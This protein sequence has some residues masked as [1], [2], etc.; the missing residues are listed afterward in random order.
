MRHGGLATRWRLVALLWVAFLVRGAFYSSVLP[1]W[2]GFDEWAHFAVA[3][4]MATRGVW[5]ADRKDPVS[6]EVL[7]S[8]RLAPEP[9]DLRQAGRLPHDEFWRLPEERRLSL[10]ASLR[11]L[12]P[13]WSRPV[14]EGGPRVYEAQQAPLYYWLLSL[15][16][17]MVAGFQL[18]DRVWLLRL[19]TVAI[20]SFTVPLTFL[21]ARRVSV[22][23]TLAAGAA[24]VVVLM[25]GLMM[26]CCRIG[27]EALAATLGALC[28]LLM[29]ECGDANAPRGRVA[30]FGAAFGLALLTKATFLALVPAV[31]VY[32]AY[33]AIRSPGRRAA[34]ALRWAGALSI[35]ALMAGWWYWQTWRATGS[36]SGEQ[37]EAAALHG[38]ALP[39]MLEMLRSIHWRVAADFAFV[40]HVWVGNWSFLVVR[41]W[42]YHLLGWVALAAALGVLVRLFRPGPLRRSDVV[43]LALAYLATLAALAYHVLMTF[44]ATGQGATLGYYL[45]GVIAAE[46]VLLVVGLAALLPRRGEAFVGPGLALLFAA[47]DVYGMHFYLIPYY[48]GMIAHSPAG[49]LET[50]HIGTLLG[51]A[52][53]ILGRMTENK[54]GALVPASMLLLWMLYLAATVSVVIY[55]RQ[56]TAVPA[57]A[58][59]ASA[60]T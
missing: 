26:L 27:N 24:A 53:R 29:L 54:A 46:A 22:S 12:A 19:V 40:T 21:L 7:E 2:E 10:E 34:V 13:Q 41:A 32:A 4:H 43:G 28:L 56:K 60:S 16:Y 38:T 49:K 9:W 52:A 33:T 50:A 39:A 47:L 1:L 55:S 48:T 51:N 58:S 6:P 30:L 42:M 57:G 44:A 11:S 59:Q 37:N 36:F 23:D 17:R 3:Q 20:A 18:L 8:L 5:H 31:L 15:V 14:P 35:A 25:P 45:D